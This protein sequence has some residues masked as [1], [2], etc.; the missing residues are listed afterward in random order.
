LWLL[1][2]VLVGVGAEHGAA[3]EA[4]QADSV[5]QQALL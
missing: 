4:A 2:A 5:L 1:V 3:V